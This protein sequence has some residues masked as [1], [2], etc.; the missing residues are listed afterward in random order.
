MRS[1]VS[2]VSKVANTRISFIGGGNMARSIIG[3]LTSRGYAAGSLTAS[4]PKPEALAALARDFGVRTADDN[5]AAVAEAEVVVLA[6]K[7]QVMKTVC[8]E[9]A[10]HLPA[11]CLVISIAAGI[12]CDSLRQWLGAQRHIVRAMPNTPALVQSGASG[13][14]AAAGVTAAEKELAERLLGAVGTVAWVAEESLIDAVTAVSGSGPAYFFLL[15]EAMVDAGEQQG[16]D[17]ATARGLAVQTALGAARLAQDSGELE[18]AELRR[19]V[20][21]PGGTTERAIAA[22]EQH[23]LRRTVAVA[24]QA[25]ADR[26]RQ[27]AD[28]LGR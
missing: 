5:A 24:M 28:E 6:V 13:L 11:H 22:F 19:R 16:L 1:L 18:L 23:Q 3:G 27:M 10:P 4:D 20:T 7:P 21:S 25:C 15:L 8:L 9:L 12:G 14:Y 17:R 26:A 2:L